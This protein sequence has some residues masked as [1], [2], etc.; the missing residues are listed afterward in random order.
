MTNELK[1]VVDNK[2]NNPRSELYNQ[3]KALLPE[4]RKKELLST[5]NIKYGSVK[6]LK[7]KLEEV[8][9]INF[10]QV[11]KPVD[12]DE[13]KKMI[14]VEVNFEW[15]RKLS[16]PEEVLNKEPKPLLETATSDEK[17][18]YKRR[19]NYWIKNVVYVWLRNQPK[20]Y[21]KRLLKGTERQVEL[22]PIPIKQETYRFAV[23]EG[24]L[25]ATLEAFKKKFIKYIGSSQYCL[26]LQFNYKK[27]EDIINRSFMDVE[28]KIQIMKK[29]NLIYFLLVIYKRCLYIIYD[30]PHRLITL[31]HL[32]GF[33]ETILILLVRNLTLIM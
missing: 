13:E 24:R 9:N 4:G 3:I 8:K 12:L 31:T 23:N 21:G 17:R 30:T 15:V 25:E 32:I 1:N 18:N 20:R 16:L 27:T 14:G 22:E 6:Y 19:Y 28:L 29:K 33:Q 26:I 7:E 2:M 5:L 11:A 10:L